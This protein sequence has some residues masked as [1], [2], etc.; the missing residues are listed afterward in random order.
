[1]LKAS[2]TLASKALFN[3]EEKEL[4]VDYIPELHSY[5][6][7]FLITDMIPLAQERACWIDSNILHISNIR[8]GKIY[9][10]PFP[11]I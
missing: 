8:L 2:Y 4:E 3:R 10:F 1:M 6:Q 7:S 9:K 11:G 5:K